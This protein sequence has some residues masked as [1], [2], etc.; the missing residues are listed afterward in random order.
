VS[1][2]PNNETL[3]NQTALT[4]YNEKKRNERITTSRA[5][6][7]FTPKRT[8]L[9]PKRYIN[10]KKKDRT[11]FYPVVKLIDRKRARVIYKVVLKR[12]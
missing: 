5:R 2:N 7:K 11:F 4:S 10:I 12:I 6:K 1:L 3:N 8:H 9:L